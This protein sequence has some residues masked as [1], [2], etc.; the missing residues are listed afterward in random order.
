VKGNKY[1]KRLKRNRMSKKKR[2]KKSINRHRG[3]KCSIMERACLRL[4]KGAGGHHDT[5]LA[6]L[7]TL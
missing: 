6:L 3:A 4:P 7:E 1:T 5:S 2:E